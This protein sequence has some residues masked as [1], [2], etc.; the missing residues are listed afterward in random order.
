[1]IRLILTPCPYPHRGQYEAR[2]E[3]TGER[4]CRS[5]QP[6]CDGSR[7]LIRRGVDPATLIVI[8]HATSQHDFPPPEPLS[9]WAGLTHEE[10]ASTPLRRR[11][12]REMPSDA[13][14][15]LGGVGKHGPLSL[16]TEKDTAEVA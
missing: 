3:D 15:K 9:Y 12:H 8:R 5:H 4:I 6:L 7:E 16:R 2:R 11:K 1:M 14:A 10:G 13:L